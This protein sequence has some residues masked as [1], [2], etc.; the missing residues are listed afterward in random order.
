[1]GKTHRIGVVADS[2]VGEFLDA[3]P[4][5][6]FTA[7]EGCELI[8]HAGDICR[9]WVLDELARIAPVLAVRGDHDRLGGLPVPET[10]VV[11]VGGKRIGLIHGRRF[12]LIDIAVIV[13]HVL[14]RR[15]LRWRAGL[16]GWLRRRFP[17]VDVIVYGHWH[18]PDLTRIDGVVL[19]SPGAVCPWGSL[20]DGRPIRP[21]FRGVSDRWVRRYRRQL[22][23]DAMRPAV[24]ILEIGDDGVAARV[25][26]LQT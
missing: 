15:Q 9:P 13:A 23:A 26:P 6:V 21:G 17:D 3:M 20:Q 16:H 25:I 24:G 1:V 10:R 18:E 4:A 14:V 2:H 22:G 12:Y 5:E 8:L 19:F 7:L 11:T